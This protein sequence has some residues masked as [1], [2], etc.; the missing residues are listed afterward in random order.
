VMRDRRTCSSLSDPACAFERRSAAMASVEIAQA[1]PVRPF[2]GGSYVRFG[3][4]WTSRARQRCAG[5]PLRQTN[6]FA[7]PKSIEAMSQTGQ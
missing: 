2:E 6:A 4:R 5:P 1:A 7:V 3:K